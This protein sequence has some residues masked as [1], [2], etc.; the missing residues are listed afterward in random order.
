ME[1][2]TVGIEGICAEKDQDVPEAVDH[3]EEEE[4]DGGP[5]RGADCVE[6][7]NGLNDGQSDDL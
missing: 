5:I 4:E 7:E 1:E 2:M 6:S 3:Q